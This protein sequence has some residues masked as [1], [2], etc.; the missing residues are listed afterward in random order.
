MFGTILAYI[1]A[2]VVIVL[3]VTVGIMAAFYLWS[4][5]DGTHVLQDDGSWVFVED[6]E[7]PRLQF[8]DMSDD[9]K[10]DY[11]RKSGYSYCETEKIVDL[12]I[13]YYTMF[14]AS[15]LGC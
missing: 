13:E 2:F 15:E 12:G 14:T 10:R 5:P 1:V 6:E 9:Q 4:L 3:V 11:L 7:E 8:S